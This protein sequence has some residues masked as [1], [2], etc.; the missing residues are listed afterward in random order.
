MALANFFDRALLSA[1]QALN[2]GDL[3]VIRER[4]ETQII[5][6]AF[7]CAAFSAVEGQAI[8]DLSV[9]L[10]ARLYPTLI[11]KPLDEAGATALPG[12]QALALAINPDIALSATDPATVRLVVG[13]TAAPAGPTTIY[14][15]SD[16]W[17]AKVS[18]RSP[19]GVGA[20]GLPFG[21]GA[22][23]CQ[24]AA[25]VFRAVFADLLPAGRLD[26]NTELSLFDFSTG[27][28]ALQGPDLE[29][30][31]LESTALVGLGAIGNGAVW[32]LARVPGLTGDLHL[33]DHERVELFNLQRYVLATQDDVGRV[34]VELSRQALCATGSFRA[35]AFVTRWDEY[36]QG[37]GHGVLPRVVAALDSAEDR[38]AVQAALPKRVLNAWTQAGDLGVSR[39]NFLGDH[40]CLA[41]LYLPGGVV[42]HEDQLIARALGLP[43]DP[44]NLLPLRDLLV[45]GKPV[46]EAFVQ[47]ATGRLGLPPGSLLKFAAEP[48]RQFYAKAICGGGLAPAGAGRP[49]LEAPLAFQSAMAGVMLA[50][51]V[52]AEAAGL[53]AIALP[54][55]TV[56]DLTR[57]AGKRLSLNVRKPPAGAATPCICQDPDFIGAYRAKHG[58][59]ALPPPARQEEDDLVDAAGLEAVK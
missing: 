26:S 14:I 2:G 55:K 47:D 44:A 53:R 36:V 40:A 4:L 42:P 25:N 9:R 39:H 27:K 28:D 29:A 57:P 54:T 1:A 18:T 24:G 33:I 3:E 58:L 16:R 10:L 50:A 43:E 11:L 15:G 19:R 12:L 13:R 6:L 52:V 31:N 49:P 59:P 32:A 45:L 5:E 23:A 46:G 35:T 48:L 56:L 41:C 22:A 20:S 8:L 7:D 37:R 51:D 21:A 30:V 17:L 38:I 34:K